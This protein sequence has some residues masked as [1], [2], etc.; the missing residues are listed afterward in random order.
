MLKSVPPPRPPPVGIGNVSTWHTARKKTESEKKEV[1]I[2]A[3]LAMGGGDRWVSSSHRVT[4]VYVPQ[5][6]RNLYLSFYIKCEGAGRMWNLYGLIPRRWLI[7][8]S[9]RDNYG[10]CRICTLAMACLCG[11]HCTENPIYVFPEMKLRGLVPNFYIRVSV[12]NLY[13]LRIGLPIWLQ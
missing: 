11:V 7:P 2:I 12:S 9:I 5:S 10:L 1:A 6:V 3:V 13:I 8:E 4:S